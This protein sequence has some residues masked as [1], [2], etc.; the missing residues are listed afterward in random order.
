LPEAGTG[1]A[2][3]NPAAVALCAPSA[4]TALSSV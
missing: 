2:T 3:A 4:T 1:P